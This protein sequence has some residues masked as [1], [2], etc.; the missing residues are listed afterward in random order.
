MI[1]SFGWMRRIPGNDRYYFTSISRIYKFK[2]YALYYAL[3]KQ[4]NQILTF[5][6]RPPMLLVLAEFDTRAI[7]LLIGEYHLTQAK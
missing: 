4:V 2:T 3:L 5:E 1:N 7:D 6:C